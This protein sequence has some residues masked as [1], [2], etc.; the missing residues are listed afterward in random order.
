MI[1]QSIEISSYIC[2][3]CTQRMV[4]S[5]TTPAATHPWQS[6]CQLHASHSICQCVDSALM[7]HSKMCT[8]GGWNAT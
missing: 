5:Y 6:K 2:S 7:N 3:L 4:S 1:V 8:Q